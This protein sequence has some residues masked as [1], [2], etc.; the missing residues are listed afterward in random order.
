MKVSKASVNTPIAHEHKKEMMG[1]HY[2]I[3][4]SYTEALSAF[5]SWV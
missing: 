2:P 4:A 5:I 3:V 1:I